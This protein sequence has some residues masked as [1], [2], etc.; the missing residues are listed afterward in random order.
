[1][2]ALLRTRIRQQDRIT[3]KA[4]KRE[5]PP[6]GIAWDGHEVSADWWDVT[7]TIGGHREHGHTGR[8]LHD[9]TMTVPFGMG[10]GHNGRKPD[11]LD[12]LSCLLSDAAGW[13]NA[14][15]YADWLSDLGWEDGDKAAQTYQQVT[16]QTKKLRR[17]LGGKYHAYVWDTE[18]R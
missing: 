9:R 4:V 6:R 5:H 7:L 11:A 3:A 16:D 13:E 12:V 15:D 2:T 14:E 18:D 17:F 1:M 8:L 10:P